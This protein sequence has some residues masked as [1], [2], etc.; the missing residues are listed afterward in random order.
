MFFLC[1]PELQA[2]KDSTGDQ[3]NFMGREPEYLLCSITDLYAERHLGPTLELTKHN[4]KFIFHLL[5]YKGS[6]H[7]H[8][9]KHRPHDDLRSETAHVGQ[10]SRFPGL[11]R[12]HMF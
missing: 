5:R 1:L 8:S 4:P 2:G 6:C 12:Q 11:L 9:N 10:L 3:G 7:Y